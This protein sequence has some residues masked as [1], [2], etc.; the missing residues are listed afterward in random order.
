MNSSMEHLAEMTLHEADA[1]R[2]WIVSVWL[3]P[4]KGAWSFPEVIDLLRSRGNIARRECGMRC[5]YYDIPDGGIAVFFSDHSALWV[6]RFGIRSD[7][8]LRTTGD[9]IQ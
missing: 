5:G 4:E 7:P 8:P 6:T 9:T 1:M 2:H 3:I